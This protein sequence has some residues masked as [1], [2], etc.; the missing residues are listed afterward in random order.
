MSENSI[1]MCIESI[2]GCEAAV[3]KML[4]DKHF[5]MHF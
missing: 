3:R 1:K 2:I 4:S 5:G